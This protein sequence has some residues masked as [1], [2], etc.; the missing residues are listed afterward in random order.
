[1]LIRSSNTHR[2]HH[3][4]AVFTH[5]SRAKEYKIY[6]VYRTGKCPCPFTKTRAH[7]QEQNRNHNMISAVCENTVYF[8]DFPMLCALCDALNCVW[9]Q[10]ISTKELTYGD[11][12]ACDRE[13]AK[14]ETA[15][16]R[17]Y[18]GFYPNETYASV[19]MV[20]TRPNGFISLNQL[21]ATSTVRWEYVLPWPSLLFALT[22]WM[23]LFMLALNGCCSCWRSS[24]RLPIGMR[25]RLPARLEYVW[26]MAYVTFIQHRNCAYLVC[27]LLIFPTT[28]FSS[29][30]NMNR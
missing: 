12:E 18:N 27:W 26:W 23:Y 2:H 15:P 20:Q 24:S 28:S 14:N 25:R 3:Q 30:P 7:T 29:Y 16:R 4:H 19:R 6:C 11:Q 10:N 21:S 13:C 8:T 22:R 5:E 1:M 17:T 9:Y